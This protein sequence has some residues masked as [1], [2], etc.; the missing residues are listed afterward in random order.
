MPYLLVR[1][2]P[3]VFDASSVPVVRR[4]LEER[5]GHIPVIVAIRTRRLQLHER[6]AVD[7][8]PELLMELLRVGVDAERREEALPHA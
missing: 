7:P 5:P 1:V 3:D 6:F 4:T 8:V 2:D